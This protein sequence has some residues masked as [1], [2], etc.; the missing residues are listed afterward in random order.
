[1]AL[2]TLPREFGEQL[3]RGRAGRQHSDRALLMEIYH[4]QGAGRVYRR[5]LDPE[6]VLAGGRNLPALIE[7]RLGG[8]SAA[9]AREQKLKQRPEPFAR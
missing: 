2:P 1:M 8:C 5:S 3:G 9:D 7:R 4:V 6:G